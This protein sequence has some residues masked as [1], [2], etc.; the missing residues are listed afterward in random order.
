M[1]ELLKTKINKKK[2]KDVF[3]KTKAVE[4][5]HFNVANVT[6][7]FIIDVVNFQR[8]KFNYACHSKSSAINAQIV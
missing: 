7:L 2:I 4:M 3:S 6:V 1:A 5:L 8:I